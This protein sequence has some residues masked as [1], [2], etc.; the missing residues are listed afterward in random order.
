LPLPSSTA[1]GLIDGVAVSEPAMELPA[2][3]GVA[4]QR[5]AS[6]LQVTPA[7]CCRLHH[8]R[9]TCTRPAPRWPRRRWPVR[10]ASGSQRGLPIAANRCASLKAKGL[11]TAPPP[12]SQAERRCKL[13]DYGWEPESAVLHASLAAFEVA[14]AVAVTFANALSR[15]SVADHLCGFSYAATD[16]DGTVTALAPALWRPCSPPATAC[17]PRQRRS[18]H[19]QPGRPGLARDDLVSSTP[20]GLAD[21]NLDGALCLRNLVTGSDAKAL[22]LQAGHGRDP[23]Q[24]QSAR[25][26]GDHRAR[27]RRR[28]AAGEPHLA[29]LYRAEPQVSRARQPAVATSRSPTPST[30][31]PSSA[32]PPCCPATTPATC[33][34]HVY[35]NRALDAVYEHLRHGKPLPASQV[36][37]TTPRGGSPGSRA[38][39]HRRQRAADPASPAQADAIG[40]HGNTLVI[41]D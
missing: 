11:L 30:S 31:T 24:R 38:G 37:R 12:P 17:R 16:A 7:R 19:Q 2:N 34:L 14:P 29:A 33:P 41:P 22:A 40:M 15:A 20:S 21:W 18:A 35:L 39:A 32:C 25:Q 6:V 13:R 1:I 26:A 28:A 8:A 5:G 4:V 23:A 3:A 36:V 9:P 10:R 27:P